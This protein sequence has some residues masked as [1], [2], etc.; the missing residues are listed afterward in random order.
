MLYAPTSE[1]YA[2]TLE[3]EGLGYRQSV[4]CNGRTNSTDRRQG[5]SHSHQVLLD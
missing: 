5:G 3:G 1:Y 4:F 2:Q